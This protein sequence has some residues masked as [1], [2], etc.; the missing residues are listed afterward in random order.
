MCFV[1]LD[2]KI[3]TVIG[4]EIHFMDNVSDKTMHDLVKVLKEIEDESLTKVAT[5]TK[6][7][8]LTDIEKKL[9]DLA[10]TPKTIRLYMQ[11]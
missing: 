9:V 3:N 4:N 1:F 6:I 2:I 5:C 7:L 10:I 11:P 8:L